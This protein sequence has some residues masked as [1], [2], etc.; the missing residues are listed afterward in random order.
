MHNLLVNERFLPLELHL[1][2]MDGLRKSAVASYLVVMH[3]RMVTRL[4]AEGSRK[5]NMKGG[6]TWLRS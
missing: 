5:G 3:H 2:N 4:E 6:R 1:L